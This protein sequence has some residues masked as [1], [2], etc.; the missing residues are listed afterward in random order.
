MS[1]S[2]VSIKSGARVSLACIQCR[3]RH[4]RCDAAK[5]TCSRCRS[6]G[7]ACFY[8]KSRRGGLDRATLSSRRAQAQ[9]PQEPSVPDAE[10]FIVDAL[11]EGT[12]LLPD[13]VSASDSPPLLAET[14]EVISEQLLQ[15]YYANFHPAQ[16]F[17]LPFHHLKQKLN[18]GLLRQLAAVMQY[19]GSL[20]AS[21]VPSEPLKEQARQALEEIPPQSSGYE[22]QALM[23]YGIALYWID[24]QDDGLRI[25]DKAVSKALEMGMHRRDYALLYGHGEK[26]LEESWRRTWW[27]LYHTDFNFAALKHME[28]F[29]TSNITTDVDLPCEEHEYESGVSFHSCHPSST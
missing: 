14:S 18:T 17:V 12:I 8:Q 3:G 5:P 15:L 4:V 19:I 9:R 1:P 24:E 10:T 21:T 20:Y 26:I 27:Y 22:V 25:F 16:P 28:Q 11:T 7:T 29:R 13:G 23:L 2:A 6:H